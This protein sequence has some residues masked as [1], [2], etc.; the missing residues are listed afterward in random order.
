MPGVLL[1]VR[2]VLADDAGAPRAE[3]GGT[4]TIHAGSL[5]RRPCILE[6]VHDVVRVQ[7]FPAAARFQ[8][9]QFR[10]IVLYLFARRML[11]L[12]EPTLEARQLELRVEAGP[13]PGLVRILK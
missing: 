5:L 10:D 9:V 12:G 1:F 3:P 11:I 6:P 4:A 13:H 7:W 8:G 2:A